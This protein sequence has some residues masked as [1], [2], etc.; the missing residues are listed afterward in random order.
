MNE[1]IPKRV[2]FFDTA[3]LA[4]LGQ[5]LFAVHIEKH[6]LA[7]DFLVKVKKRI[8]LF[9]RRVFAFPVGLKPGSSDV[10]S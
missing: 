8:E 1:I 7:L 2:E 6:T 5:E 10:V 4:V 3:L 9:L